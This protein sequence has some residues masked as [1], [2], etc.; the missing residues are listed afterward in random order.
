[1]YTVFPGLPFSG[2]K[3]YSSFTPYLSQDYRN[4]KIYIFFYPYFTRHPRIHEMLFSPEYRRPIIP[5]AKRT[6]SSD[7]IYAFPLGV[8]D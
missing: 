7:I 1:M 2:K 3:M 8:Q 6:I 5:T 4:S